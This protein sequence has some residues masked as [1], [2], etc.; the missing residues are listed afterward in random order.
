MFKRILPVGTR[1]LLWGVHQF[2]WHPLTV[3]R[4]WVSL[5]GR[6]TWRE[7]ICI[8]IHDWGYWGCPNMD[9]PEGE[10]HP[11]LGARVATWLFGP[12]YGDLTLL[13]SR[14][15][16]KKDGREPS[17]LCW[18]D[19]LS[20]LYEPPWWYLLRAR[21]SGELREYRQLAADGGF[22]SLATS[23]A[24]WFAWI[25]D[26]FRKLATEQRGDAVPYMLNGQRL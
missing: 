1:S 7:V 11:R 18:A 8:I 13:H 5:Y 16:A 21:L 4:A 20:H 3:Y 26:R 24:E 15:L 9:G 2:I 14:H 12:A 25:Q 10:E 23:D 6:P 19:K 17:R 22:I